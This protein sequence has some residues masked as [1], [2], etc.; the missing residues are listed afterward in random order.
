MQTLKTISNISYNTIDFFET[1]IDSLVSDSVI[2]WAYWILHQADTDETKPHIHFVLKPS[3]RVDT[4]KL[5]ERF[6]EIDLNNAKPLCCTVKWNFTNSLDDWLL[7]VIHDR[8]YLKAKG[9]QRNIHYAWAEV[10]ATDYDALQADINA[11]D[12]TKFDRL[13]ILA[14]AVKDSVPFF[15]LVQDGVIP[16]AQR[17]QFEKQYNDIKYFINREEVRKQDHEKQ[18][19]KDIGLIEDETVDD[20]F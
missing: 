2:D 11:I 17:S 12:R 15:Q 8:A 19:L 1:V 5:R 10:R 7:Y 16:I 4:A 13:S 9:Q 6:I 14:Q 3:R 20:N 18:Y